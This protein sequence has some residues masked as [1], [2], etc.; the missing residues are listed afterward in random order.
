L[1]QRLQQSLTLGPERSV[2][3]FESPQ[4]AY[5]AAS[6]RAKEDD[7]ILVFGSFFTVAAV[8]AARQMRLD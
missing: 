2:T 4:Q 7:R 3:A 5:H 1:Q 8:I 6:D